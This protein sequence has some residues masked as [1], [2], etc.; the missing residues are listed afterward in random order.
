MVW[1]EARRG[2][3]PKRTQSVVTAR[4]DG[5][6][7]VC[8]PGTARAGASHKPE[9]PC[10]PTMVTCVLETTHTQRRDPP[11]FTSFSECLS[12]QL[13]QRITSPFVARFCGQ[14]L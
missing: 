5:S 12:A 1:K 7:C 9:N 13:A 11:R 4:G 10:P 14:R 2:D 6:Q 3:S 8:A